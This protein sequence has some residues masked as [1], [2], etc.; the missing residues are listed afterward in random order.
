MAKTTELESA[1]RATTYRVFL[2]GGGCDLR[3]GVVSETLRC[4]LETAGAARFAIL[5]A[6]NPGS[7][8]VESEEN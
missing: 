2:P 5:T 4:W 3:L 8:D 7:E 6:H 1:Y